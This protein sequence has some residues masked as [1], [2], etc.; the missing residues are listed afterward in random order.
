[1]KVASKLLLFIASILI[2]FSLAMSSFHLLSNPSWLMTRPP[3]I[4]GA[5]LCLHV[6]RD[7]AL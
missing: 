6:N 3:L 5:S 4:D 7:K 1:M 2:E